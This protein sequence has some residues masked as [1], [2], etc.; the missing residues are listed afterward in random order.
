MRSCIV[1]PVVALA[2]AAIALPAHA[3]LYVAAIIA[4]NP[5]PNG[6]VPAF[7]AVSGAGIATFSDGFAQT[8]LT[9]DQSYEY[10]VQLASSATA[11]GAAS[12]SYSIK[13]GKTVIQSDTIV[14]AKAYSVGP[15]GVWVYCSGYKTLPDSPGAATLTATSSYLATGKYQTRRDARYGRYIVTI[16]RRPPKKVSLFFFEKKDQKTFTSWAGRR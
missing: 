2:V 14:K 1:A 9:H 8:V 4:S 7:N 3:Q 15:N 11:Q 5:D 10:C 12:V 16:V 6:K 13:R